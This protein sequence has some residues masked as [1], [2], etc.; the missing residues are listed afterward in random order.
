MPEREDVSG[1]VDIAVVSHTALT[2]GPFSYTQPIDASWP[3]QGAASRTGAGGVRFSH[4]LENN[5][6]VSA[7]VFQHCFQ[8]GP[9]SIQH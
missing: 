8:H 1:R 7:L 4:F 3:R 9:A 2:A 6:C 5:A